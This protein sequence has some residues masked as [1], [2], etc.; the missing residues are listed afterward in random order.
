MLASAPKG[1]N[2]PTQGGK[3]LLIHY[4]RDSFLFN[5]SLQIRLIDVFIYFNKLLHKFSQR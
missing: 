1:S 4:I 2:P 5:F 3:F